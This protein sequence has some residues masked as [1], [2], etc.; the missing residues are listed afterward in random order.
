ME[1]KIKFICKKCGDSDELETL[2]KIVEREKL[3]YHCFRLK[4]QENKFPFSNGINGLSREIKKV[5][6]KSKKQEKRL[7]IFVCLSCGWECKPRTDKPYKC[8]S[9]NSLKITIKKG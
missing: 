2:D 9:C 3:C 8:S 6:G 1:T 7:S 5:K 4:K